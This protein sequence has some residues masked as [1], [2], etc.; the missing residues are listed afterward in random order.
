MQVTRRVLCFVLLTLSA[1][2]NA[3]AAF[4]VVSQS[5][6]AVKLADAEVLFA[7][8]DRPL[9]AERLIRE[10]MA[11]YQ[12]R[13]D[14]DGLGDA[15]R[16]YGDLLMSPAVSRMEKFY[17]RTGFLDRTVPFDDRFAKATEYLSASLGFY[18]KAEQKAR[19]AGDHHRVALTTYDMGLTYHLLKDR[20]KACRSLDESFVA[21]KEF[22]QR[23]PDAQSKGYPE[24]AKVE[25][26]IAGVKKGVGCP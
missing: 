13:G 21:Y 6:P 11:I 7:K 15:N 26:T 24:A 5:D 12:E 2:L 8:R 25:Q 4:G 9:P 23:N 18:E 19:E 3:C 16:L 20:E 22:F 14:L 10:A 17:R 1:L